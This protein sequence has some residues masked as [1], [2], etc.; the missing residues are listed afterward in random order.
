MATQSLL[1]RRFEDL[2]LSRVADGELGFNAECERDIFMG[3]VAAAVVDGADC[4]VLVVRDAPSQTAQSPFFTA[5]R[6]LFGL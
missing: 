5:L 2:Q 6:R 3:D 4:A 1:H